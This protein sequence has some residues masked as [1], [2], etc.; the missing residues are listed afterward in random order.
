[1]GKTEIFFLGALVLLLV[2][3]GI[4]AVIG[5][6]EKDPRAP[7]TAD[8][9]G[10]EEI[11]PIGSAFVRF[12]GNDQQDLCTCY[13]QA[14]AYADRKLGLESVEYLGG[15]AA[16]RERLGEEG[17]NAWTWGWSNAGGRGPNSCRGYEAT[18]RAING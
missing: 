10:Y 4:A 2:V 11:A 16:C 7:R 18:L 14:Y 6:G 1:M 15:F 3:A 8:R 9:G 13:E 17:G 5:G 12:T